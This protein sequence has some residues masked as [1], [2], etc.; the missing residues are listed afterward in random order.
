[1]P[2]MSRVAGSSWQAKVHAHNGRCLRAWCYCNTA[3]SKSF[4]F[5][6]HG[7]ERLARRAALEWIAMVRKENARRARAAGAHPLHRTPRGVPSPLQ[8][9]MTS[10]IRRALKE[11]ARLRAAG[12]K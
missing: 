1:M 4:A 9:L 10:E 2:C 5:S 12:A 11:V 8:P 3:R 6:K 7:G